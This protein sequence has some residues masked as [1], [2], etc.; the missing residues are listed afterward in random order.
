VLYGSGHRPLLGR[1][2][3]A[4]V[5]SRDVGDTDLAFTRQLAEQIA[6][7]GKSVVSG[8]ARGVDETAMLAALEKEGTVIG[9][10]ANDLLK[11]TLSRKYRRALQDHQLVLLSPFNPEARFNAGN[12]MARNKFIYCLADAAVVVHS[13]TRGG[14]WTGALENLAGEW[15]PL[16]IKP[17]DDPEA[18][19]RA[20]VEKGGQWLDE[21]L[22]HQGIETLW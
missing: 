17:S 21:T 22:L 7:A 16:W 4:I 12:A 1:G 20:L 3:V 8:G 13:G 11:A 10:L 9:V 14:T 18:G 19:N 15:V 5:G 2:G 6:L